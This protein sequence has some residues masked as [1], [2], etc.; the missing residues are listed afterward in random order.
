MRTPLDSLET[1]SKNDAVLV[2]GTLAGHVKKVTVEGD[3]RIAVLAITEDFAKQKMRAGVVRVPGKGKISL[4]TDGVESQSPLL[5]TGAIIPV[6]SKTGLAVRQLTSN[7][8]LTGLMVGLGIIAVCLLVFR[9]LV[10][11]W[12]LVL[13]LVLSATIAWIVLPWTANAV[14][15]G[16]ALLPR[17]ASSANP[18]P[19]TL[20]TSQSLSTFFESPPNPHMVAYAGV[21]IAA[22]IVLSVVLRGAFNRLENRG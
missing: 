3:K 17:M 22:F 16:F 10:R 12:L 14:S 15:R 6:I 21:F 7:R 4:R 13:T 18:A 2:D 11:G 5:S 1:F 20:G 8:M 9:R 19:A